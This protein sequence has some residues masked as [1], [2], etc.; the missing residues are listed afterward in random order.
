MGP[1]GFPICGSPTA[2]ALSPNW[3]TDMRL[4]CLKL[5]QG[6][7]YILAKAKALARQRL[8]AGSSEPLL[9]AYV[10]STIF[11]R[12]GSYIMGKYWGILYSLVNMFLPLCE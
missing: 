11:L 1:Y 2:H 5:L 3:A 8:C 12:G 9:V 4:F 7:F 6:P 10:I